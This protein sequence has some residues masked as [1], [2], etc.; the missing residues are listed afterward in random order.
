[1]TEEVSPIWT[2]D[3]A[4]YTFQDDGEI[5]RLRFIEEQFLIRDLDE[6]LVPFK[7]NIIQRS[8]YEQLIQQYGKFQGV[9]EIILKARQ[10][11][12]C[13]S[14]QSKV[15]TSSLKW[16]QLKDIEVGQ[17]I[18]G[19][20]ET[21]LIGRG[22]GRK[23]RRAVVEG[24]RVVHEPA[25][26]LK[27]DNGEELIAT[28][29]HR[30]LSKVHGGTRVVWKTVSEFLVGDEIRYI[31]KPWGDTTVEDAWIGGIIDGEGHIR[32]KSSGDAEVRINQAAGPVW[33][34]IVQYAKKSG[35]SYREDWDKRK[36]G[37]KSKWGNKP[38]GSITFDR[39]NEIFALLG[40]TQSVRAKDVS[41][42]EGKDLPGKR[43][44]K[45]WSAI[46]SI[47]PL[48]VQKMIDLQTSGKTFVLDGFVSHN[49][50]FILA[51]FTV[52]FLTRPNSVSVCISHRQDITKKLFKKVRFY[53]ESY[54]ARNEFPISDY[55]S[56]D[57]KEELENATNG[58][59]FYIG[60]AGARVGGR[61]GTVSN[62]HFCVGPETPV[63]TKK[64]WKEIQ[65]IRA[66]D[67]VFDEQ[68]YEIKVA[69]VSVNPSTDKWRFVNVE[70]NEKS[71]RITDD[72]KVQVYKKGSMFVQWKKAVDLSPDDYVACP[73][74]FAT[75]KDMSFQ[76]FSDWRKRPIVFRRVITNR[77]CG[78]IPEKMYDLILTKKPHDYVTAIGTIH[79]SECAFFTE[80]ERIT[81]QEIVEATMQQV[82]MDR[83]MIFIESTGSATGTYYHKVWE[84]AK[85][86]ESSFT[87]R[88]FS[89][90]EFYSPEWLEKKSMEYQSKNAFRIDYPRTEDEAFLLPGDLFFDKQALLELTKS[91]IDPIEMGRIYRDGIII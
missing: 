87:P 86:H 60:T 49:S 90:D 73:V 72:H 26:R 57:T 1:M 30:F 16:V 76:F 21:P 12:F 42:W 19:V 67:I 35:F 34:K 10:Q 3:Q 54:C 39:M 77:A 75:F 71:I 7:A 89:C 91:T 65:A 27:M 22:N 33:E 70:G 24:K 69:G 61:G 82:P 8:Y 14:E 25:F 68:G 38:V 5:D 48:G 32:A 74:R 59:F 63:M 47:E 9:R 41:W 50:S 45:A 20:D 84:S 44:G 31:T 85:L 64:G 11:G 55:L 28:A 46:V 66:G 29:P 6:K 52:D 37:E 53:I 36:S 13:A 40:K 23:M 78:A 88:F 58:S 2:P 18:V 17:E 79:N 62:L 15:L 80:S 43:S 51:L 4:P 56:V 83:G 81:A